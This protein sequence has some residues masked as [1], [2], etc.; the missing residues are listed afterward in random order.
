MPVPQ[1]VPARALLDTGASISLIDP[2]IPQLLGLSPTGTASILT[3]STGHTPFTCNEYDVSITLPHGE[4]GIELLFEY[5]P[6]A[7]S[8]FHPAEGCDVI[9]GRNILADCLLVYDGKARTF[10]F[11]F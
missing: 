7:E 2:K 11:S 9:I 4:D 1:R 5:V 6:V 3:A 8:T 10:C